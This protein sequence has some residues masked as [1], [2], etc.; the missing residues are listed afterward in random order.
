MTVSQRI[1]LGLWTQDLLAAK[2][3]SR[4]AVRAAQATCILQAEM[5]VQLVGAH[6]GKAAIQLWNYRRRRI[7]IESKANS[8]R[9]FF[10]GKWRPPEIV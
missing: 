6:E 5:M 9:L 4:G 7:Y 2:K 1:V 10:W 8:R 3:T